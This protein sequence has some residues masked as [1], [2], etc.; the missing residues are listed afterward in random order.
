[1]KAI[2]SLMFAAVAAFAASVLAP[3]A[4]AQEQPKPAPKP[5]AKQEEKKDAKQEPKKEEKAGAKAVAPLC[6][7][8]NEPI[9]GKSFVRYQG[10]RVYLCCSDCTAEFNKSPEKFA[11]A[12]KAQWDAMPARRA[13]I[14]CPVTGEKINPAI[15]VEEPR[16]DLCFA[17]EEAKAKFSKDR[18]AYESKLAECFTFQTKCPTTGN[19][20]KPGF[21]KEI[22]GQTV[23]FC[24][25]GCPAK[26]NEET[27][28]KAAEQA[29]ANEVAYAKERA[30]AAKP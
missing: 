1:M 13:Q 21:S 23:Y 12:I 9:D 14:K 17:N 7:V 27:A 8:S 4:S 25:G 16:Y 2:R 29:K 15:Y 11:K 20:I 18:K 6:P 22:A 19:P 24:C 5:A 3:S 28:K 10:Q 26:A 30:G